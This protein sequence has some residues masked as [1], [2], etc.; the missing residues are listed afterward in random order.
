MVSRQNLN[1]SWLTS[2]PKWGTP[3]IKLSW[4]EVRLLDGYMLP[5]RIATDDREGSVS[6]LKCNKVR[7]LSSLT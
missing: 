7:E 4:K 1:A 2:S 6:N 5:T 3:T